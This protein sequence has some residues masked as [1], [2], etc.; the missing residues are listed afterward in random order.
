MDK[1]KKKLL[2]KA[3]LKKGFEEIDHRLACG[4]HVEIEK[5]RNKKKFLNGIE[6]LIK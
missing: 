2:Q 4:W 1:P 3:F 6:Q 5:N